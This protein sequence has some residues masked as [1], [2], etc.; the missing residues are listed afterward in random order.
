[1]FSVC[2]S[3]CVSQHASSSDTKGD[4]NLHRDIDTRAPVI[5]CNVGSIAYELLVDLIVGDHRLV[6]SRRQDQSRDVPFCAGDRLF[7]CKVSID[8]SPNQKKKH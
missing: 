8:Q 6:M 5:E 2:S 4:D 1:M 3:S 7:P